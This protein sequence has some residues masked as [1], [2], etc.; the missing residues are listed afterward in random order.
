MLGKLVHIQIPRKAGSQ[1]QKRKLEFHFLI[2]QAAIL[3]LMNK[4][5]T[6]IRFLIFKMN[7]LKLFVGTSAW[8]G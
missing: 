5:Q 7:Q 3:S 2:L 6:S 8:F 1:L 4:I